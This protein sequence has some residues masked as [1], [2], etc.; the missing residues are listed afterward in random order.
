MREIY[1]NEI[2]EFPFSEWKNLRDHCCR[3]CVLS[4]A[5]Q[6]LSQHFKIKWM[7]DRRLLKTYPRTKLTNFD[8]IPLLSVSLSARWQFKSIEL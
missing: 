8:L 2:T 4:G 5:L 1:L 3:F 7:W 6:I